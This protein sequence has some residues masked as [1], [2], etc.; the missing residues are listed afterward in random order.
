MASSAKM[1]KAV[2]VYGK[3]QTPNM[4]CEVRPTS[5]AACENDEVDTHRDKRDCGRLSQGYKGGVVGRGTFPRSGAG[6]V[7]HC[8]VHCAHILHIYTKYYGFIKREGQQG[9]HLQ[10]CYWG[11]SA[12]WRV[13]CEADADARAHVFRWPP[14]AKRSPVMHQ[15][16]RLRR[17]V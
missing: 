11:R 5:A 9:P 17:S 12:R 6:R 16:K 2:E 8:I 14:R 1:L 13:F 4:T 15:S 10:Y 7:L 3:R